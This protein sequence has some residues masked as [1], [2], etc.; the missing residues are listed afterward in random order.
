MKRG[1]WPGRRRAALGRDIFSGSRRGNKTFSLHG[2]DRSVQFNQNLSVRISEKFT[3]PASAA[4]WYVTPRL[5]YE[6][7]IVL[8]GAYFFHRLL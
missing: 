3:V 8:F 6:V 2:N 1:P 7:L 5:F 4:D